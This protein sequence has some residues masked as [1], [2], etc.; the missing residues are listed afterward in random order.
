MEKAPLKTSS[1][2]LKFGGLLGLISVVF[3]FMLFLTD[4][5]VQ[6]GIPVMIA[7]I[8]F[9]LTAILLGL[10]AFKKDNNGYMSVGQ[11]LKVGVGICLI[12]GIIGMLFQLLL[13]YVLD[14]EMLTKQLEIAKS[15][16]LDRGLTMEQANAQ[17]DMAKKMSN[18]GIQ[19]AFGLI[20]SV[21]FGF[22]LTLIP[23]LVMKKN[24]TES[25]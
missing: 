13:L 9:M 24:E 6:G 19:A 11:A 23:A 17:I 16:M 4:L 3:G 25:Y 15:D 7:S 10:R 5:H 12:G 14:P 1:Y 21:F 20:G 22:V 8:L 2:A 18:P